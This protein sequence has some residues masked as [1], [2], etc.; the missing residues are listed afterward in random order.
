[1]AD[2]HG[3]TGQPRHLVGVL[4]QGQSRRGRGKK[5]FASKIAALAIVAG[6]ATFAPPVAGASDP[7]ALRL[8][9]LGHDFVGTGQCF[10]AD[11]MFQA[12]FNESGNVHYLIAR[13]DCYAAYGYLAQAREGFAWALESRAATRE[14]E[15]TYM[16]QSLL[17][18]TEDPSADAAPAELESA[19]DAAPPRRD[20]NGTFVASALYRTNDTYAP[21]V[22]QADLREPHIGAEWGWFPLRG[23]IEADHGLGIFVR[24]Y[25]AL[26]ED[27]TKLDD[28][29]LQGGVGLRLSP[30]PFSDLTLRGEWLFPIGENAREGWMFSASQSW[31]VGGEWRSGGRPWV[32]ANTDLDA[33]WLPDDP[34][35][36]AASAE[37][38]LGI[39]L[40]L[41]EGSA[42]IPHGVAAIRYSEDQLI[43]RTLG[44]AGL[45]LGLRLWPG[46]ESTHNTIDLTLQYRWFV[47]D[48]MPLPLEEDGTWIGRIT[49][50]H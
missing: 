16:A 45:G 44:E 5:F 20:S 2:R 17:R 39:A 14:S 30:L 31:G 7:A 49:L 28:G 38:M 27:S 9:R 47:L 32:V 34:E 42:L 35:F 15:R 26:E 36:V 6:A 23:R 3:V 11:A 46:G 19:R 24:A 48:D 4:R 1:M 40:P 10:P 25:G 22:P 18:L 13:A 12:A 33:A 41:G 43:G 37:T 8:G 29:S 21:P 50:R